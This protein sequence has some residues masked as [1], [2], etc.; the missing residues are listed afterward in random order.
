MKS[1][2]THI[3]PLGGPYHHSLPRKPSLVLGREGKVFVNTQK[4]GLD[5]L[6]DRIQE[7]LVKN[8]RK[9]VHVRGDKEMP[10]KYF[11][12]VMDKA[13]QAGVKQ[14]NIVHETEASK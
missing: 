6:K 9:S 14:I 2:N 8:E 13:R 4:V 3:A 1:S 11:V 5:L 10:Y 7:A 12:Q